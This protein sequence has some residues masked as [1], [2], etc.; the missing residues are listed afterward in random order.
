MA[1]LVLGRVDG[2]DQD[3]GGGD[4]DDGPEVSGGFLATQGDAFE[5]F[6][7]SHHLFDAGPPPVARL[8]EV[9]WNVAPV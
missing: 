5:A 4:C 1:A 8:G 9:P 7:L 2:F 6:E 3:E